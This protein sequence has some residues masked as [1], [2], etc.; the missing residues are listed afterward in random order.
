MDE[1]SPSMVK[2]VNL[3]IQETELTPNRL[4]PKK[5]TPETSENFKQT[6]KI[7]KLAREGPYYLQRTTIHMTGSF[8]SE[9]TEDRRKWQNIFQTCLVVL[10]TDLYFYLGRQL[11]P[12]DIKGHGDAELE[13]RRRWGDS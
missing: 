8:P 7:L 1:Y 10:L 3:Q 6:K 2:D 4:Y 12:R 11:R 5:S 13:W 9:T